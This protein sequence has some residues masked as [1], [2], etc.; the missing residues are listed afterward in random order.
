MSEYEYYSGANVLVYLDQEEILECAG[1]SYVLQNSQQ[2]VYGYSSQLYDMVLP[3][4][5]IVQGNLLVNYVKPNYLLELMYGKGNTN[6]STDYNYITKYFDIK[7]NFGQDAGKNNEI[8]RACKIISR[9][10]T[11]QISE[12]VILEEYTFIGRSVSLI[13]EGSA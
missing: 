7:V 4:R 10:T 1:I 5:T 13:S 6:S 9:G 3:G 2:P 11:V 12:Q 8:I